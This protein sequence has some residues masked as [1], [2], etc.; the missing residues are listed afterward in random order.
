MYM[1]V[2]KVSIRTPTKARRGTKDSNRGKN[3]PKTLTEAKE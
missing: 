3:R 1:S 2:L